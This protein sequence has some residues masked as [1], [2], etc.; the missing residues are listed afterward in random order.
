MFA[1]GSKAATRMSIDNTWRRASKS[2]ATLKFFWSFE[3]GVGADPGEAYC[4]LT[5]SKKRGGVGMEVTDF[6]GSTNNGSGTLEKVLESE[7]GPPNL[8]GQ[9][10]KQGLGK[11]PGECRLVWGRSSSSNKPGSQESIFA[12]DD[13]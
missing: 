13:G 2:V 7:P 3:E 1:L 8:A 4:F 5:T 9:G 6:A 10:S 12:K 11:Q